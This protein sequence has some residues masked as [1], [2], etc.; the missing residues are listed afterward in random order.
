M[1]REDASYNAGVKA[2]T[3][4]TSVRA[5]PRDQSADRERRP[6]VRRQGIWC[7][8]VTMPRRAF[9]WWRCRC[10]AVTNGQRRPRPM[11]VRRTRG[12]W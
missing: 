1:K 9:R 8:A 5:T 3:G 2:P 4:N 12:R 6:E 11:Y 7:P 10:A